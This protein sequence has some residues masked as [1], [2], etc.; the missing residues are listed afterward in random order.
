MFK[1]NRITEKWSVSLQNSACFCKNPLSR[2][3][4]LRNHTRPPPWN[5][6]GKRAHP[7]WDLII[8]HSASLCFSLA[9][10][11]DRR[12]YCLILER[13]MFSV[14]PHKCLWFTRTLTKSFIS[15]IKPVVFWETCREKVPG[16]WHRAV[17]ANPQLRKAQ[18]RHQMWTCSNIVFHLMNDAIYDSNFNVVPSE[19]AF[20]QAMTGLWID[21]PENIATSSRSKRWYR[22]TM[23]LLLRCLSKR[24]EVVHINWSRPWFRL[25]E[26]FDYFSYPPGMLTP[27]HHW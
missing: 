18:Q 4:F 7:Q 25:D 6:H 17:V 5:E 3:N 21:W 23:I 27:P 1:G 24:R 20:L 19:S 15:F 16:I 13:C 10:A 26:T 14:V 8:L 12:V 11:V 2:N 22:N 9:A